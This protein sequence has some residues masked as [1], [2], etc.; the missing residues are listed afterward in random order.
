MFNLAQAMQAIDDALATKTEGVTALDWNT[1][2]PFDPALVGHL[3][4]RYR[5]LNA[6]FEGLVYRLESDPISAEHAVRE[7]AESLHKLRHEESLRL[8]PVI[9]RGLSSDPITRRLFWQSRLV[10]LGLARRVFRR[11]DELARAIRSKTELA[12]AADH[13]AKGLAEYRRRNEAEM[14]PLYDLIGQRSA[15]ARK[16]RVA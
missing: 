4:G 14:Y 12:N 8:Y 16:A 10:M 2:V 6:Q 3:V 7:C 15:P 13:A 11:F 9:A 5:E 1:K